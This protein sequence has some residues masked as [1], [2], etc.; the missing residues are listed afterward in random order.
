MIQNS[1]GFYFNGSHSSELGVIIAHTSGEYE[2]QFIAPRKVQQSRFNNK[3]Y[4]RKVDRDALSFSLTL[5]I[6]KWQDWN[7]LRPIARWLDVDDYV[8]F[9]TDVD[10]ERVYYVIPDGNVDITHNGVKEGYFTVDFICL[11]SYTYSNY[12]IKDL[13]VNGKN[14]LFLAN[15][16]D[17]ITRPYMT[18][19][20][21]QDGDIKVVNK[22]SGEEFILTGLYINEVIKVDGVN[23]EIESSLEEKFNRYLYDN[24]NRNW[25]DFKE[26]SESEFEFIGN[27]E[28]EFKYRFVYLS[29]LR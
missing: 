15:E 14:S 21:L 26:Q 7:K 29:E 4:F 10:P 20:M 8:E 1:L 25:L 17:V 12:I 24:H 22:A 9:F 6:E 18:F 19:K 13:V 28:V 23:E 3:T 2:E 27:F 5:Y 16:G 11:D